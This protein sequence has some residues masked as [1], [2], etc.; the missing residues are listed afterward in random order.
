MLQTQKMKNPIIRH[1]Q[2][3]DEETR[4]VEEAKQKRK[5][6]REAKRLEME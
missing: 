3:N 1:L 5:E 4:K 2:M 6:E